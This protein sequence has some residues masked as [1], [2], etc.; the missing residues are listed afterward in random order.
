MAQP[1][2]KQ[3]RKHHET[4]TS[5]GPPSKRKATTRQGHE[6]VEY[7]SVNELKKRIRNAKRLLSR[8]DLPADSRIVQERALKGFEKELQAEVKRRQRKEMISRYHFVRFLERK[9]ATKELNRFLRREKELL[10]ADG[11]TNEAELKSVAQKI[12]VARVNLNYTIYYPLTEKY[13]SLYAE[14]QQQKKQKRQKNKPSLSP[15]DEEGGEARPN[16][17]TSD[18]DGTRS[19]TSNDTP[20]PEM[21]YVIEKYMNEEGGEKALGLLR[22]GELD[23]SASASRGDAGVGDRGREEGKNGKGTVEEDAGMGDLEGS[24]DGDGSDGGFFEE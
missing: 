13:I 15:K 24:D 18:N 9:S 3:K 6:Q 12:H 5:T 4:S 17:T 19:A 14:Q 16:Q 10:N 22:E 8:D 7:P 2:Q 20:K 23:N 1:L 21:W 11:D